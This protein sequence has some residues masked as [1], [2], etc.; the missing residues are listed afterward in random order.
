MRQRAF[1]FILFA[2]V[3]ISTITGCATTR[4]KRA[5]ASDA[6][7]QLTALQNEIAA[8]DQEIEDLQY[9]LQSQ[10][11]SLQGGVSSRDRKSSVVRVSGVSLKDVQR[12]LKKAGFDPGPIDGRIGTKTKN[13]IKSFQKKNNLKADGIVGEKTWALLNS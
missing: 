8:K 2:A 7:S 11:Q 9:Q 13:A 10:D 3:F 4:A 12:A 6:Q 1:L 5:D